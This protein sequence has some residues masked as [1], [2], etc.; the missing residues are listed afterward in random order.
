MKIVAKGD[1]IIL[2]FAF[3]I[4]NFRHSR[5]IDKREN[6]LTGTSSARERN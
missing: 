4:L 2:I 3:I 1:T 5:Q 6:I